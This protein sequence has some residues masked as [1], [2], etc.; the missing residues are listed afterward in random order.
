MKIVSCSLPFYFLNYGQRLLVL[1]LVYFMHFLSATSKY[2]NLNVPN[3][4]SWRF[5]FRIARMSVNYLLV[6][7]SASFSICSYE[8]VNYLLL[9]GSD[10]FSIANMSV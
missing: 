4:T 8:C 2:K 10:S 1:K 5:S 3:Y 7:G 6:Y 9:C